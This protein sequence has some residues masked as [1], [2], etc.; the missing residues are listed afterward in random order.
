VDDERDGVACKGGGS[1]ID[2]ASDGWEVG[3]GVVSS[4]AAGGMRGCGPTFLS[5]DSEEYH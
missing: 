4:A 2:M 5:S 3:Q 1:S